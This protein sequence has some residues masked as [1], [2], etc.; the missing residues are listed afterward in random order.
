MNPLIEEIYR[1]GIVR[2]MAGIEIAASS[3]I[4]ADE[5][6]L[7]HDLI[8]RNESIVQTLEIGC[9]NGLSSLFICDALS[10][11]PNASHTMVDPV[12][13]TDWHGAGIAN[14]ERAGFHF[15]TLIEDGSEFVLPELLKHS[16]NKFDLIL[17][18]GWHTFDHSL[19]DAFFA[20]RLLRVG[21]LLVFD[22]ADWSSVGRTL[23]WYE[24]YPCYERA[25]V[26]ESGSMVA[27]R[28]AREDARNWDWDNR[29]FQ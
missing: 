5:G 3:G 9:A 6:E 8:T 19:V 13:S 26:N 1:S 28:K 20:T 17:I 15:Y 25:A 23:R 21:G 18:D 16:T 10:G 27:L 14:L 11:R 12:Q 4:S 24:G 29:T 7:L 2:T 22:D